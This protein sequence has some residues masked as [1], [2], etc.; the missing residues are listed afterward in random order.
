MKVKGILHQPTVEQFPGDR[1]MICISDISDI[2]PF[3][4]YF[5]CTPFR[6]R[7]S[8]FLRSPLT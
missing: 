8:P 7:P 6:L 3:L 2:S 4:A 5:P 1:F